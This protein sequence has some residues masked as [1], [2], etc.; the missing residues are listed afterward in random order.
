MP[1]YDGLQRPEIDKKKNLKVTDKNVNDLH[2]SANTAMK[3]D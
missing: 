2:K 3:T 1:L